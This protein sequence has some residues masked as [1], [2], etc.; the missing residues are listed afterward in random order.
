M[1]MRRLHLLLLLVLP[2]YVGSTQT[3]AD[4]LA[5]LPTI[6]STGKEPHRKVWL[7]TGLALGYGGAAYFIYKK[8][9]SHFREES[10]EHKTPFLNGVANT[11][12]PLGVSNNAWMALGATAGLA[13][14]IHDTRLQHAAF[15]W[16]GSMLLNS[17]VTD[18]LKNS[19]QRYRPNTGM[20]YNS[21]DGMEGPHLNHSLPSAHTSNAFTAATVFAT[22]YRDKKWVPPVAYGLASLVGASRVYN[23]A[24]WASDVMAGAAIG[25]L[26]AKAM[27][28]TDKWLSKKGIR[29]Y[30]QVGRRGASIGMV[31]NF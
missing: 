13:Y 12:S 5:P 28:T 24:H 29:L 27:L 3:V 30:P 1:Y 10:Q 6:Q 31:K 4:T 11:V 19:F 15:V 23:N 18:K 8:Q 17:T 16:A 22:L 25:F 20:P 7:H 26:S 21:F 9:D 2:A 14:L